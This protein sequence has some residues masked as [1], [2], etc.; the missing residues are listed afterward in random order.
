MLSIALFPIVVYPQISSQASIPETEEDH[1]LPSLME[2]CAYDSAFMFKY[3]ERPGTYAS[4]HF[5]G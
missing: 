4:K 1:Q 2:K 3:S 5:A